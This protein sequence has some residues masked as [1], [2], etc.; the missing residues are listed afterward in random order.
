LQDALAETSPFF[1]QL[2]EVAL[3]QTRQTVVYDPAYIK[4]PYPGGGVPASRGVCADVIIRA[5]RKFGIDLQKSVH[6]DMQ[7]HF[8]LYPKL[9]GL[10]TTDT[11]IDHRRVPNLM[12]FFG[13]F[14]ERLIISNSPSDF[15]P[16]EMVTWTVAG[17]LPHI[18][19]VSNKRSEDGARYMIVHNIGAGPQLEDRLFEWP[20]TGHFRFRGVK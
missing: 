7:Q 5:Y 18:G 13:R 1:E 11:N 12:V 8:D 2:A 20:M 16:G 6:E 19:F 4:I 10:R 3:Q 15:R 9:W 17:S 14:G